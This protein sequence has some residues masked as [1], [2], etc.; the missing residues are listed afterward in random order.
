MQ[1]L[2]QTGT[3]TKPKVY[4]ISKEKVKLLI[5]MDGY[6]ADDLIDE[7]SSDYKNF[8]GGEVKKAVQTKRLKSGNSLRELV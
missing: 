1:I 8:F 2:I 5:E 4:E 7:N 3:S 6:L